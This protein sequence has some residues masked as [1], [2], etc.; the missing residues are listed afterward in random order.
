MSTTA[1]K[2]NRIL[3]VDDDENI[4]KLSEAILHKAGYRVSTALSAEIALQVMRKSLQEKEDHFTAAIIDLT[5][6]G[7]HGDTLISHLKQIDPNIAALLITGN[8]DE[9]IA[10]ETY[11]A[12]GFDGTLPK[13]FSMEQL[14]DSLAHILAKKQRS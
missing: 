6:P 3:V 9:A 2:S 1:P 8:I 5:L 13:P 10:H 4:L 14:I 11:E 7:N 12:Y